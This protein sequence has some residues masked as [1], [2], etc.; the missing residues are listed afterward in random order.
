MSIFVTAVTCLTLLAPGQIPGIKRPGL[1]DIP[2]VGDIFKK[3]PAITTSLKDCKWEDPTKD[4]FDPETG[5]I[6]TLDRSPNGGFVLR[7]GG[8]T[9]VSQSYC[10]KAGTHGPGDGDGYLYAPPKGPCES[11]VMAVVRNSVSHPDIPQQKIQVLLWG[12]IARTKIS[13][14]S[15]DIQ[16]VA[17]KLLTPK[18]ILDLNGGAL[19][20]LTDDKIGGAFLKEPPLLRQIYEAEAKL[21][22]LLTSP[23]STFE[24]L[25]R[26]AVL[27][28]PLA[29][30]KDSKVVPSGRWSQH[31]DGYW[32]R[33]VPSGYSRTEVT[34]WVPKG[35][36]AVGKEFDPAT[37]IAV[38]GNTGRQRLIQS[39][40]M[41]TN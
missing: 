22:N 2:G 33:Y 4:G 1:G 29:L 40:R 6:S 11:Q 24:Q 30:Q 37:H 5:A 39:G 36:P 19:G 21:R 35:S 28:G 13:D 16:S 20:L 32:I 41:Q 8:W 15:R 17:A 3:G 31:P 23:D 7:D 14:M 38:P 34:V 9:Y 12:I 10:L 26:V 27:N 25:E 18:Q